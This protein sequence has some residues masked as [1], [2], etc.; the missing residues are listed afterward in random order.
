MVRRSLQDSYVQNF[1]FNGDSAIPPWFQVPQSESL[2]GWIW[3]TYK[4]N[5]LLVF[6]DKA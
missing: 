4:Q 3:K 2:P 5:V 1:Y 6:P